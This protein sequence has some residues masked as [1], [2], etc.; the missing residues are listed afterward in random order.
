MLY[1]HVPR[2]GLGD[3]A[4]GRGPRD[5][6]VC[7]GEGDVGREGMRTLPGAR[8]VLYREGTTVLP[9]PDLGPL[10]HNKKQGC[11]DCQ[12]TTTSRHWPG[13]A[14]MEN[15]QPWRDKTQRHSKWHNLLYNFKLQKA[16]VDFNFEKEMWQKPIVCLCNQRSLQTKVSSNYWRLPRWIWTRT[17]TKANEDN[18]HS[19]RQRNPHRLSP[20][21]QAL[22]PGCWQFGIYT[23]WFVAAVLKSLLTGP[24]R[25]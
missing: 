16:W 7:G 19:R 13:D 11:S 3:G 10:S 21:S 12:N 20:M 25:Y 1:S 17:W 2:P 22:I 24:N 9:Q 18:Y 5:L 15:A 4:G 8:K 6:W 23:H 14:H